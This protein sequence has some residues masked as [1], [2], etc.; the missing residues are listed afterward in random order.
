[1]TRSIGTIAS[2]KK[3]RLASAR[4]WS[5][6][7]A[8]ANDVHTSLPERQEVFDD[9]FRLFA[10]GCLVLPDGERIVGYGVFHPWKIDDAPT[11]DTLMEELP[12]EP[13][14]IFIHDVA[15]LAEARGLG[16]AG[17][18]VRIA[19]SF[20]IGRRLITLALVSVYGSH[21]VWT[22]YGFKTRV[23]C[24]LS[25]VLKHYGDGARYMTVTLP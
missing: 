6:I 7:G 18:F 2:P 10:E 22:K 3:W 19:W 8:I 20:A 14:C 4:E 17:E 23:Y 15:I 16:A 12:R 5:A 1:M 21:P 13:Q 11:L 9:K 24:G 25:P